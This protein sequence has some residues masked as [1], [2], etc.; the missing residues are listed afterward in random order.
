[1]SALGLAYHEAKGAATATATGFA[2]NNNS[3]FS[4]KERCCILKITRP[5]E[6]KMKIMIIIECFKYFEVPQMSGRGG[7]TFDPTKPQNPAEHLPIILPP[8]F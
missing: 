8:H 6:M 7:E 1:M 4:L 3:D 2:A 5:W